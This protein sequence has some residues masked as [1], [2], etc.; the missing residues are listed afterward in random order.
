MTKCPFY[1]NGMCYS[2]KTINRYGRPTDEVV[3]TN[4]CLT[5]N[6]VNCPFYDK[7]SEDELYKYMG[8]DIK[9]DFYPPIHIIPCNYISECPYYMIIKIGEDKC[10]AMCRFFEKYITRSG[11][12]KCIHLWRNCPYYKIGSGL[13]IK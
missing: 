11:V 5:P 10:V 2:K 6:Y 1:T 12:E 4:Y 13:T 8:V 7:G 3:N 9:R